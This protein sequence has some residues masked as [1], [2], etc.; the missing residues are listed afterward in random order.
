MVEVFSVAC[1]GQRAARVD[2]SRQR[3][4]V[5]ECQRDPGICVFARDLAR[6]GVR[7]AP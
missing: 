4:L 2:C 7:G 3:A 6:F 1:L 5:A